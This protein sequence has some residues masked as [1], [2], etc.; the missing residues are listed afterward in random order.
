MMETKFDKWLDNEFY[1]DRL[2]LSINDMERIKEAVKRYTTDNSILKKILIKLT[3][4][5]GKINS[6]DLYEELELEEK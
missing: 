5:D 2:E 6:L 3:Q 4:P 1:N